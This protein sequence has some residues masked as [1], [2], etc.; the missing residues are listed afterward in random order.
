M[1]RFSVNETRKMMKNHG[2]KLQL[3]KALAT[4]SILMI[5]SVLSCGKGELTR[6]V[7][8][9]SCCEFNDRELNFL[10]GKVY[11][12]NIITPN[13]DGVNDILFVQADD[14]VEE[15]EE[16][17]VFDRDGD[18]IF[19]RYNIPPNDLTFGWS[20]PMPDEGVGIH[21]YYIKVRNADQE[22]FDSFRSVCVFRCEDL[23]VFIPGDNCGFPLQHNGEG[24][25]DPNLPTGETCL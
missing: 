15:I 5:L 14:E 21:Q 16:F 3:S 19:E 10:P 11:T 17:K 23:D 24:G 1:V 4:L 22:V 20:P 7:R 25:F 18:L 2:V 9:R 13:G 8:Y 6:E 12:A